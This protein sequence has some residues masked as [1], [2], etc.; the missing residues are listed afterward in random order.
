MNKNL[1]IPALV[2]LFLVY[3]GYTNLQQTKLIEYN[4]QIVEFVDAATIALSEIEIAIDPW[5]EGV[6]IEVDQFETLIKLKLR[7]IASAKAGAESLEPPSDEATIIAFKAAASSYIARYETL[8]QSYQSTIDTMKIENPTSESTLERV[9][10]ELTP[11]YD[12]IGF[13]IANL[14]ISQ[15]A[16]ADKYSFTLE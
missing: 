15:K 7:E 9:S 4:D 13:A 1:I 14:E 8:S 10:L 2:L 6:P 11:L 16:M 3:R 12:E 5:F